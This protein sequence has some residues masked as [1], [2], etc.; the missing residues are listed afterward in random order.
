MAAD[1]TTPAETTEQ[2]PDT[3]APAA[4]SL[5]AYDMYAARLMYAEIQR[6]DLAPAPPGTT[7]H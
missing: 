4:M 1:Q 5:D 7:F 2:Q 6:A 3:S